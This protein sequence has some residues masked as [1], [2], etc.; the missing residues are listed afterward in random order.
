MTILIISPLE[1]EFNAIIEAMSDHGLS[2]SETTVG[3]LNLRAAND[4]AM[5][6]AQGGL[7]KAQFAL[8]TQHILDH[9]GKLDLVVCA[10]TA[11][12]LVDGLRP[13]DV[14]IG[15]ETVEHDFNKKIFK[16][17]LPRFAGHDASLRALRDLGSVAQFPFNVRFGPI[18]SGDEA[19]V[20]SARRREVHDAT[21]ALA[22][23][24][25][26]AGGARACSFSDTPYLEIRGVSDLA[27]DT[28]IDEFARNLPMAMRNVALVA[29]L[30]GQH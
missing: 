8:Q 27:D 29:M 1:D 16:S 2:T 20:D 12:C 13:G 19:I 26:G 5:M 3:R 15:T 4:G 9:V 30:L 25:E 6:I 7:G 22:V 18:A 24:W 17:P 11:G 21:G 10:G 23:A 14:V 28:A